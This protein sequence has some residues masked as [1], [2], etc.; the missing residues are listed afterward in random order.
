[1]LYKVI[2]K[3]HG[4][5]E[6]SLLKNSGGFYSLEQYEIAYKNGKGIQGAIDFADK[7]NYSGIVMP[8]G[9]YSLCYYEN[10]QTNTYTSS[11]INPKSNQIIDLNGSKF[12]VIYDS[13]NRSPYH[14]KTNEPWRLMGDIFGLQNVINVEI[15]NGELKGDIY[16]RSFTD[17]GTGFNSEKGME[18]SYGIKILQNVNNVKIENM[19]IHGFMGDSIAM[20]TRGF[21]ADTFMKGVG[22]LY[23]SGYY[24]LDGSIVSKAGSYYSTNYI[25]IDREKLK[26]LSFNQPNTLQIQTSGGYYRVP[27]IKN[28]GIEVIMFDED[29]IFVKKIV[30]KYLDHIE[31][32]LNV[33][34]LK[35]Q[36]TSEDEDFRLVSISL[37]Q[38]ASSNVIVR[39]C[40]LH[41]NH[42]GGLSNFS[43]NTII[44][45]NEIYNNGLDSS[46]GAPQFPDTTR[47]AINCEDTVSSNVII[48][49]NNI[50]NHFNCMLIG[51]YNAKIYGNKISNNIQSG[52]YVVSNFTTT[53]TD[54]VFTESNSLYAGNSGESQKCLFKNNI[55]QNKIKST[56]IYTKDEKTYIEA[57]GNLF[58]A[59]QVT[60]NGLSEN[61]FFE[62]NKIFIT[63]NFESS[64]DLPSTAKINSF[65]NNYIEGV[66][67]I[68]QLNFKCKN[69]E[70]NIF[71]NIML[72]LS[73]DEN[74]KI[75]KFT[76]EKY[77]SCDLRTMNLVEQ[78]KKV[79]L[80]SCDIVDSK[81]RLPSTYS[82]SQNTG[83]NSSILLRNCYAYIYSNPLFYG[84][85][86]ASQ[87]INFEIKV[88][89]SEIEYFVEPNPSLTGIFTSSVTIEII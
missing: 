82:Y 44:E 24:K 2:L 40:K 72:N 47:Y 77:L 12:D 84:Q 50:Y 18:Q 4:I 41:N 5:I 22:S 74:E 46:I 53:V 80:E 78:D 87:N 43:D 57:T 30:K 16:N 21:Q 61:I 34:Y 8:K 1:M 69:S 11:I 29:N 49:N 67:G 9:D 88:K 52:V 23:T 19:N 45:D 31:L 26:R 60:I 79:I 25:E 89:N 28:A 37:T 63:E 15:I 71:K 27:R 64:T 13:V 38:P 68:K 55:I 35:M 17:T 6:G 48:R 66:N 54:N 85:S 86:Y 39:N 58:E 76:R 70:S 75:I 10:N 62:N 56:S 81:I 32:P 42:R 65:K 83:Y 3:N 73:F 20:A 14:L 51:C 59:P 33:K 36:F 7:N